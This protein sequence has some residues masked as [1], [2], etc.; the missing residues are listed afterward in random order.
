MQRLRGCAA[1][2]TDRPTVDLCSASFVMEGC[3]LPL[4]RPCPHLRRDWARPCPHLR[5]D[6]ARP[7]PHLRRD[8]ARTRRLVRR[9]TNDCRA[10][11]AVVVR[12]A[13]RPTLNACR[14]A[15]SATDGVVFMAGASGRMHACVVEACKR[16]GVVLTGRLR[17]TQHAAAPRSA[18]P[19]GVRTHRH[20]LVRVS[21]CSQTEAEIVACT[22]R[23]NAAC[24][25]YV[26]DQATALLEAR[27]TLPRSDLATWM[28]YCVC[29]V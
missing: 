14:V 9:C 21:G 28:T 16:R 17:C 15:S 1:L 7:C 3:T 5:R 2:D 13:A 19:R 8:S 6:W 23:A 20:A 29:H 18:T 4:T 25:V 22:V 27:S 24:G 11:I 10:G 12:R 26:A